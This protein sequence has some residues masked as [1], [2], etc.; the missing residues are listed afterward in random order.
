MLGRLRR[1]RSTLMLPGK[2]SESEKP[3]NGPRNSI[4]DVFGDLCKKAAIDGEKRILV[5][6]AALAHPNNGDAWFFLQR[7]P[8]YEN[9]FG[10]KLVILVHPDNKNVVDARAA[11]LEYDGYRFEFAEAPPDFPIRPGPDLGKYLRDNWNELETSRMVRVAFPDPLC[12]TDFSMFF[13]V[14][15]TRH[16][17]LG[18]R[19]PLVPEVDVRYYIENFGIVPGKTFVMAPES[20]TLPSYPTAYW[21]MVAAVLRNIGY[22]VIFNTNDE[23]Y[24]GPRLMVPWSDLLGL[25]ELCGHVYGIRSGFFDFVIDANAEFTII[26]PDFWIGK[27]DI[28]HYG[29]PMDN[30]HWVSYRNLRSRHILPEVVHAHRLAKSLVDWVYDLSAD[31]NNL[32]IF[33]ATRG[34]LGRVADKSTGKLRVLKELGLKHDLSTSPSFSYIAV[35]D[36][37]AVMLEES[38]SDVRIRSTYDF[39]GNSAHKVELISAGVNVE[40]GR[41]REA[42]ILIDGE[43]FAINQRGINFVIW[44]ANRDKFVKSVHFDTLETDATYDEHTKL[45]WLNNW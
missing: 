2:E 39:T 17:E 7:V 30:I 14:P 36:Q 20:A 26:A 22:H 5:L 40:D 9:T 24:D 42:R 32:R 45:K 38:A 28:Q 13:N 10:C 23:S 27:L 44:D 18:V 11:L 4:D 43:N 34:V 19:K 3:L 31:M 37:G 8:I 35:I 21:N 41:D 33:I 6:S 1:S 12:N 15:E 16:V 29:Q 25:V